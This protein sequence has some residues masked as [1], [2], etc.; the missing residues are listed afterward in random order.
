MT[1]FVTIDQIEAATPILQTQGEGRFTV[2]VEAQRLMLRSYL[3]LVRDGLAAGLPVETFP[4]LV[5]DYRKVTKAKPRKAGEDFR[6]LPGVSSSTHIGRSVKIARAKA[7]GHVYFTL[8]DANRAAE[9]NGYTAVRLEG[10]K[11]FAFAEPSVQTAFLA[12]A[13][14]LAGGAA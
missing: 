13:R 1:E 6:G 4:A 7:G 12:R 14:A 3:N 2:S 11:G 9:G 8:L 10:I 5:L